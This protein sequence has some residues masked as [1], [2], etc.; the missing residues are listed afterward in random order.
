MWHQAWPQND[1]LL[2]KTKT[3]KLRFCKV[4]LIF[5][6]SALKMLKTP[7]FDVTLFEKKMNGNKIY[8][9]W[10]QA[11]PHNDLLLLKTKVQ[12]LHHT[13]L[14]PPLMWHNK[15]MDKGKIEAMAT[16]F[17]EKFA[18]NMLKKHRKFCRCGFTHLDATPIFQKSSRYLWDTLYVLYSVG[19]GFT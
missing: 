15:A 5:I 11:W 4:H 18:I 1:L 13:Y 9:L 19:S 14:W 2:L 6:L 16:K 8:F 3:L 17:S 7:N 12:L 10:H